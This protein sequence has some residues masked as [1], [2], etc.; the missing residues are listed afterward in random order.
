MELIGPTREGWQQWMVFLG[1]D[2]HRMPDV[3]KASGIKMDVREYRDSVYLALAFDGLRHEYVDIEFL[4]EARAH[5]TIGTY[6]IKV[7]DTK[8]TNTLEK[9]WGV[10]RRKIQDAQCRVLLWQR[11]SLK[12]TSRGISVLL[13]AKTAEPDWG[14]VPA[15]LEL[16]LCDEPWAVRFLISE[17]ERTFSGVFEPARHVHRRTMVSYRGPTFHLS[18]Y[19]DCRVTRAGRDWIDV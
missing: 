3:F 1:G 9:A 13:L 10:M 14:P 15:V 2:E 19:G 17:L 11:E 4:P 6:L 7:G 18:I 16:R 8:R 12:S 5:I